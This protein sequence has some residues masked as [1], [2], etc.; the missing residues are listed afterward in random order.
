[1]KRLMRDRFDVFVAQ[2]PRRRVKFFLPAK[3]PSPRDHQAT[4]AREPG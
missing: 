1:M 4:P 2:S 3:L